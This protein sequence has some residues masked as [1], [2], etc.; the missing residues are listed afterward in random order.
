MLQSDMK[1]TLHREH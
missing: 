1:S